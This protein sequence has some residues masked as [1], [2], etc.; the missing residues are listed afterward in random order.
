MSMTAGEGE[1]GAGIIDDASCNS[2]TE[3]AA[4]GAAAAADAAA[5]E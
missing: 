4:D 5:S 3:T 1:G 2:E